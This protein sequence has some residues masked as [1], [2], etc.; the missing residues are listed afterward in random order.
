MKAGTRLAVTAAVAALAFATTS[1]AAETCE[2]SAGGEAA[3]L[4]VATSSLRAAQ[5]EV[6]VT[7]YPDD[8]E[9]FLA[10]GGKL[11][12]A[13]VPA[14]QPVTRAC[15]WLPPGVYAVAVYH[16]QN[17]NHAFDRDGL[18]RP[19]EGFGFSNDAPARMG[20]PALSAV[21]FRLP[22]GGR[23]ISLHMRYP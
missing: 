10:K 2:G 8:P 13:R 18:G 3:K 21:R 7:V 23:T 5:G 20:V 14:V 22:A 1:A 19:T 4:M 6:A 11:L 17:A 9:R 16:D 15:F 12:R